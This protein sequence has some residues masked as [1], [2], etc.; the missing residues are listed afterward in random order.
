MNLTDFEGDRKLNIF[1]QTVLAIVVLVW[2]INDGFDKIVSLNNWPIW[3]G[4]GIALVASWFSYNLMFMTNN[5]DCVHLFV[6]TSVVLVSWIAVISLPLKTDDKTILETITNAIP[7]AMSMTPL[8]QAVLYQIIK[9]LMWIPNTTFRVWYEF[10]RRG[11][12]LT[13]YK[14]PFGQAVCIM[15]GTRM[16]YYVEKALIKYHVGFGFVNWEKLE[17]VEF[18]VGWKFS[19]LTWEDYWK[20]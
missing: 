18:R 7:I 14:G 20:E 13:W 9:G 17:Y 19:E 8:T 12:I 3:L 1:F 6:T 15:P 16:P 5:K 10:T 2:G 11:E 4:I